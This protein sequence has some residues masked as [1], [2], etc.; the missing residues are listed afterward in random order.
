M[1]AHFSTVPFQMT[2]WWIGVALRKYAH[3]DTHRRT[4]WWMWQVTRPKCH[5]LRQQ[6]PFYSKLAWH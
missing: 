4:L 2:G 1:S 5:S 6:R 3:T